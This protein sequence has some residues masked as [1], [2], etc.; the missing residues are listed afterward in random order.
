MGK[1]TNQVPS[2]MLWSWMRTV[3][4]L[5]G[6]ELLIFAYLFTQTFDSV[7]RCCSSLSDMEDWFGITRQTISRNIDSLEEKGLVSK[8]CS[9]GRDKPFIKHNSYSVCTKR[10]VELCEDSDN[11]QY[12]NFL[13][14]Y[15]YVLKQK[16]PNDSDSIDGFIQ[17]LSDFH[18]NKDM[19]VRIT[20][21]E[22]ARLI[23][24]K[25][26]DSSISDVLNAVR[27]ESDGIRHYQKRSYTEA[28]V[29]N[30]PIP[31]QTKFISEPKR[32][33]R[34]TKQNE[35]LEA[36]RQLS[37]EFVY[38]KAGGNE[39]LL[40]VLNEFLE[41]DAGRSYNPK[42]WEQQLDNLYKYGR[43]PQRMVAGVKNSY[44]NNYRSLYIVDKSEVDIDEK[45]A[46]IKS[47]VEQNGENNPELLEYLTLY[48]TEVPKGKSYT[49]RQFRMALRNLTELC[50][51]TEEKVESVKL[52]YTYS[53]ASLAYP[54]NKRSVVT[55]NDVD[56]DEKITL[57][58]DFIRDGYYYL[59]DGLSEALKDYVNKT[60]TGKSCTASE[61]STLLNSLRLFCLNDADKV[62]RVRNAVQNNYNKLATED[63]AETTRIKAKLETRETMATSADR[64]RKFRVEQEKKRHPNDPRLK[65]VALPKTQNHIV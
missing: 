1:A 15:R 36:K 7:H 45:L 16:Y 33:T 41:T 2:I 61:F 54:S 48:I 35:W 47:Y 53:Y 9:F 57:V 3:L 40:D 13:E 59:C 42:Q 37:S 50:K 30:K 4:D 43:T 18:T 20:V 60:D 39:E 11:A 38:L 62:D 21:N 29:D 24:N 23:C 19:E 65:D 25:D 17:S 58:D 46:E 63:F 10:I 8:S 5:S 12:S 22:L 51:T 55:T 27:K 52:S 26:D 64:S 56:M 49:I 32:K 31:T 28:P 44:M 14:S 6:N 34:R